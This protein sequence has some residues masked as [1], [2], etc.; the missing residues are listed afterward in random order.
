MTDVSYAHPDLVGL[1][2]DLNGWNAARD[3]YVS[4]PYK[5][6]QRVLDAGCGTGLLTVAMA[7]LGHDVVGIDPAKAML[8]AAKR[9]KGGHAVKWHCS[10]LQDFRSKG[11]FDL[12]YMT[13]HAFQCLL[14]D[15]DILAAF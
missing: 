8:K 14:E 12:I 7:E 6:P 10:M 11:D 3:F 4:W 2:D 5:R 15:R 9:R 1:Y 13:G